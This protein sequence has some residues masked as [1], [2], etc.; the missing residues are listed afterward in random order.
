[1]ARTITRGLIALLM[2][3]FPSLAHA[4]PSLDPTAEAPATKTRVIYESLVGYGGVGFRGGVP[5][6]LGDLSGTPRDPAA[7]AAEG[8][9]VTDS[10]A[11]RL[12][13]DLTFSYVYTDDIRFELR[14][15]YGWNRLKD[16]NEQR[17]AISSVPMTIGARYSLLGDQRLLRPYLGAGA[18][19]YIWTI[20][21][22]DLGAGKDPVTFERLRRGDLGFYLQAGAERRMSKW[23][24]A[25][26]DLTYNRILAKDEDAFPA[27]YNGNKAY[28]QA[29]LGVNFFFSLSERLDQGLP[30]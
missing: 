24:T 8:P 18:G 12:T 10:V 21:T 14:V 30:E 20:H 23:V 28:L 4:Q 11:P 16:D 7:A 26:A 22:K 2:F 13:G 3:G 29:R 15:G 19:A 25:T 9:Y 5:I 1:M 17:F 27:G 6:F